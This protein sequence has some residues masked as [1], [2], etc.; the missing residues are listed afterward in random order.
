[1]A[2]RKHRI[3]VIGG[4]TG[5][6]SVAARLC[7]AMRNPDVAVLEPAEAH[8]YQPAWTLVGGL[9]YRKEKTARPMASVMPRKVTWIRDAA[10]SIDPEARLVTTRGGDSIAYERLVVAAGLSLLWDRIP[11]LREGLG[12]H[13]VCSNYSYETVDFTR[14]AIEE[15]EG[16][17]AIF[18]HP[19]TPIKCGGA[20][21]K[22]MYL[23]DDHWRRKGIREKCRIVF[24]IANPKIFAVKK[25]ADALT[26]VIERKGIEVRFRHDLVSLDAAGGTAVIRDLETGGDSVERFEM[27]HVTPPMGPPEFLAKSPLANTAGWVDVDAS[28]LRHVRYPDVFA[29][30][31]CSGLP[32]S[33]TAAAIRKQAPVL[34]AN[35]LASL[36]GREGEASYHGYTPCPLVTGY[37]KLILA[38][39]NYQN[40][41]VETFP[42]DQGKERASMYALKKWLLPALYWNGM[43]KGRA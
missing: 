37:G 24:V 19:S 4:G 8:Y 38:E 9:A 3:L 20:P 23:A 15:F 42:F 35:L 36:S 39:F 21:Q 7:R 5:G 12:M 40:E 13:G 27:L 14:K 32:T 22:I 17:T 26:K 2:E 25:Y 29:L 30:G 41:P 18:T 34:V 10:V 33:K 11:G 28:S 43:L 1:M 31:D 16:G 6:I